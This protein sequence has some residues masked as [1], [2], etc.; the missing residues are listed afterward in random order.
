MR[1]LG[2]VFLLLPIAITLGNQI[3]FVR[4]SIPRE[5]S[6]DELRTFNHQDFPFKHGVCNH[7]KYTGLIDGSN[8]PNGN[9]TYTCPNSYTYIGAW[10]HGKREGAGVNRFSSQV[11]KAS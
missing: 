9:G 5:I 1:L 7:G 3:G 2:T 11:R 6:I 4:V 10:V 8:R